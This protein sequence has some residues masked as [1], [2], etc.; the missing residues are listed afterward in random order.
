MEWFQDWINQ[1]VLAVILCV[2]IELILPENA[3][4]KYV[5][6]VIEIYLVFAVFS[7]IANLI[8]KKEWAD[9]SLENV[10]AEQVATSQTSSTL[11]SSNIAEVY[12]KELEKNIRD[13]LTEK[14]Y[15]AGKI[16]IQMKQ[17]GTY[18]LTEIT[19]K[20]L[21]KKEVKIEGMPVSKGE[22]NVLKEWL[23][24]EYGVAKEKITLE[25]KER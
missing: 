8:Q 16:T 5:K 22:E 6:T 3:S 24:S 20:E 13:G 23:A 2:L 7:P 14:G 10:F 21:E 17:D 18:A 12:E 25:R 19:I 4:R 1:I 11:A 9:F 15:L